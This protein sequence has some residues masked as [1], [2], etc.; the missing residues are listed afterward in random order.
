MALEHT[1]SEVTKDQNL[2]TLRVFESLELGDTVELT[3]QVKVGFRT[4]MTT[5]IGKVVGAER[6]RSG[7]HFDRNFDDKVYSDVIVLQRSDGELT[8]VTLDEYSR[9]RKVE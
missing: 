8:T 7:L 1:N 2:E 4:W 3:H 6:R 5:T 9:L